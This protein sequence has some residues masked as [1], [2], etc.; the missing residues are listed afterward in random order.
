MA[1]MTIRPIDLDRDAPDIVAM[2]REATPTAVVSVE[3]FVHRE[4][5]VPERADRRS[6]V[7]ESEGR[8]VGRVAVFR[9]FF[10]EGSNKGFVFGNVLESHRGQG[11]GSA[12]HERGLA[13]A[14]ELGV[15]GLLS[16]FYENDAGV[17]FAEARGYRLVRAEAES[18]VDPRTIDDRPDPAVEL[19]PVSDIDPRL[20]YEVDV[21]SSLDIPA[22]EPMDHIPYD[23]W[24]GHVLEHPLFIADGSFCAMVDGIAA[25][26]SFLCADFESGR[27]TN[28]FTGT[29]RGYRGRGLAL[30]TKLAVLHWSAEH[31]ITQIVTTNDETN[32]PMLAINR[33]LGYRPVGR[34][35]E[36]LLELS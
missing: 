2:A 4:R 25:A 20:V 31:G 10:T 5:T 14:R 23:E 8:V 29:L 28:M 16:H 9:N 6:W 21:Q 27:G 7:A 36:Y 32:A 33:R 30:A 24:I 26:T 19:L 18:A 11:I 35:V 13:Y 34:S 3:S 1:S 22:T 17:A 15:D 12:L